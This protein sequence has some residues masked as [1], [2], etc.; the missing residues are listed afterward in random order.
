MLLAFHETPLIPRESFESAAQ[1]WL[2]ETRSESAPRTTGRRLTSVRAFARWAKWPND[3]GE[4]RPPKPGRTIPHPLPERLDG[5]N[6][7]VACASNAEQRALIGACGFIGLRVGEALAF[8][9]TW[10]DSQSMTLT[11]RGKGDKE[12]TVPV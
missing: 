3:L 9:T 8:R 2:D 10:F 5:L 4:Y 11:I 12:R 1:I 6:R 7:L